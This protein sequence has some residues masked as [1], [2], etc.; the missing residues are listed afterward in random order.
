MEHDREKHGPRNVPPTISIMVFGSLRS[1]IVSDESTAPK[2]E[3]KEAVA[4]MDQLIDRTQ[5]DTPGV[6]QILAIGRA[7]AALVKQLQT[8]AAYTERETLSSKPDTRLSTAVQIRDRS[9][10]IV[11]RMVALR[12]SFQAKRALPYVEKD[13]RSINESMQTILHTFTEQSLDEC[14]RAEMV[15]VVKNT[16]LSLDRLLEAYEIK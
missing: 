2:D 12:P 3:L 7:S 4:A 6:L 10:T 8:C 9:L 15:D 11:D 14:E 1:L 5:S 16:N 13:I